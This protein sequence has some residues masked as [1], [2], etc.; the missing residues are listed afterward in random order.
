VHRFGVSGKAKQEV[1]SGIELMRAHVLYVLH[2]VDKVK[3]TRPMM[4]FNVTCV[5]VS[6]T[7]I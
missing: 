7:P 4:V 6:L 3:H 5:I 2:D 1:M